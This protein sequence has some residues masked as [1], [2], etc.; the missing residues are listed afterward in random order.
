MQVEPIGVIHTPYQDG[1]QTPYQP[2]EDGG[3]ADRF[4]VELDPEY[5]TGLHRLNEFR[6]LYLL[7][8]IHRLPRTADMWVRPPWAGGLD[9]GVFASRSPLRPNPIGLSVVRLLYIEGRR[10]YTTGLD[11][12]DG[13]PLLDIKPYIQELDVKRDAN[14]G[15]LDTLPDKE[16]LLLHIAGVPHDY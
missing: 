10:L 2:V 13:T 16:H 3:P 15:W 12:F 14:Y 6:Y 11:V 8:H 4:Y 9:V 5:Q 7:Y 1:S